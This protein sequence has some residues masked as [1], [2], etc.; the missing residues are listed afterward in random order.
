MSAIV[1]AG[2]ARDP[3]LACLIRAAEERAIDVLPLLAGGD[4]CPS[5]SWD[6]DAGELCVNGRPVDPTAAFLRRDVFHDGDAAADQRAVAWFASVQ[7][8][9]AATRQVRA[10][11]RRC[12]DRSFNK[13]HALSL[14]KA[15]NLPIPHT[16]VTNAVDS[17]RSSGSPAETIAKPVAGGGYCR[18]LDQLPDEL[19]LRNGVSASPAIVQP[20]IA[21]PDIRIYGIG[22]SRFGFRIE[23]DSVDYR[24]SSRKEI[25][26]V[27]AL[28]PETLGGLWRLTER[29]GLDWWA[30]DFKMS[31]KTG[32][33]VFLEINSNPMF[34]A[35]D[36]IAEGALGEAIL[37][38][39]TQDRW[40]AAPQILD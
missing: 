32:D 30:A 26:P 3:N 11:N 27:D 33:L 7:G 1:V 16:C 14:A 10:P 19:E 22:E 6:L 8:W 20:L 21:G 25:T 35:F 15:A 29:M 24:I 40:C 34:S 36:R 39:L 37:Q 13:L 23:S 17:V 2:G 31:A 9:L 38:F 12:L 4:L 5:I 18:S 28:P